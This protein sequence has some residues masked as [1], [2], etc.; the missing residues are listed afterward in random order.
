M[1]P[2]GLR[3]DMQKLMR[4]HMGVMQ[5]GLIMPPVFSARGRSDEKKSEDTLLSVIPKPVEIEVENEDESS[6]F[7]CC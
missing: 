7:C 3:V 6:C 2:Q 5:V 4:Q 1:Q